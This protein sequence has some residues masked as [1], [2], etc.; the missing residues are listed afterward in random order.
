M[1]SPQPCFCFMGEESMDSFVRKMCMSLMVISGITLAFML[2]FTLI[3]V[4][5]RAFRNPIV[6]SFEVISFSGAI[7]IGFALPYTTLRKGHVIVDFLLER[8]PPSAK[9][10]LQAATRI[11]AIL[12]FLWIG[13]NFVAMGL[14]LIQTKEVTPMFK[15][16]F[17]PITFALA[18]S[19]LMQCLA[20]FSEMIQVMGG[21][22]G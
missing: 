3:D 1:A 20:L 19:C 15:L 14:D 5:L 8:L 2:V 17:Y 13:W 6:G 18:F 9:N 10:G 4:V 11:V 7:A 16:P 21:R 22:N 12:L